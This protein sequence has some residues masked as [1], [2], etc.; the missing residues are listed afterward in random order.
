MEPMIDWLLRTYI[1]ERTR[2]GG[3]RN[4]I[5]RELSNNI[6]YDIVLEEK[7]RKEAWLVFQGNARDEKEREREN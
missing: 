1:Y 5:L 3:R 2:F 6:Q 4:K 7:K